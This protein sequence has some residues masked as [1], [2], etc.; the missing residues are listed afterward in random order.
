MKG[1]CGKGPSGVCMGVKGLWVG[2][3]ECVHG[4]EGVRVGTGIY[5]AYEEHT[6]RIVSHVSVM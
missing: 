5:N 4:G 3:L 1:L 2:T 6:Y